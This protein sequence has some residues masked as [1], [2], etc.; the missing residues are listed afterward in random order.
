[1]RG[2]VSN[3]V[4]EVKMMNWKTKV[5]LLYIFKRFVSFPEDQGRLAASGQK[6]KK[7][8]RKSKEIGSN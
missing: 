8:G 2:K 3:I 5:I 1:M 7:Q 4:F 6:E